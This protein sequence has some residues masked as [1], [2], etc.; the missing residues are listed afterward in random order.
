MSRHELEA[1]AIAAASKVLRS[2]G[3]IMVDV[4]MTMGKLT[5]E[6]YDRRATPD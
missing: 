5:K 2:K 4:L 1:K 3:Y 6:D